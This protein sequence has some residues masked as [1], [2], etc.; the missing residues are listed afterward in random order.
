MPATSTSPRSLIVDDD[1]TLRK[2]LATLAQALGHR[3]DTAASVT[4]ALAKLPSHPSRVLLDLNLPDGL[5]TTV[6]ERIRSERLPIRVAVVSGTSDTALLAEVERLGADAVFPK[7][8]DLDALTEW[9]Q[10]G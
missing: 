7:P 3:A 6:L 2:G 10:A 9:L 8:P 1:P 5:G 4:E